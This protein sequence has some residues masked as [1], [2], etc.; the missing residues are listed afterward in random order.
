MGSNC[1]A[2]ASIGCLFCCQGCN[3][4]KLRNAFTFLPPPASYTVEEQ[5]HRGP[6]EE[7]TVG[8]GK[9][10]YLAEGLQA[11]SCYQQA[12]DNADVRFISTDGG[13]RIPVVW[14]RQNASSTTSPPPSN[15]QAPMVLLHCHGNATDI[16]MMMGPYFELTKQL[17]LDVVGVEYSGYGMS[18]GSPSTKTVH[19]DIEA[20]YNY[21]VGTG[22]PA[23]RI[24]AYGQSVGS[25]PVLG[26]A[27][28]KPLG[29]VVLHS[30]MLSGIKV[31]DPEPDS[32]CRPSC[33]Y[34]C[35]DFFPNDQRMK[36]VNCPAFVLHG[37]M[38]D[39][40]PFYHGHRLSE[41]TPRQHRWPSYFPRGA[42]HNDIVELNAN[43]YFEE[44]NAFVRGVRERSISGGDIIPRKPMQVEMADVLQHEIG[45]GS[46]PFSEPAVGPEDG[47]YQ[48]LRRG[49]NGGRSVRE[50][51]AKEGSTEP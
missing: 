22:V 26:L 45:A 30:P 2:S 37:Q 50:L 25:G 31:I 23:E 49:H 24:V 14:V 35:F 3:A 18:T 48:T 27:A 43:T 17:G 28:R 33:V 9:L 32:C 20:A 16:G 5:P 6:G 40:I 47:R 19:S 41:A 15:K 12:A 13:G 36:V 11:Y 21:V 29:G 7:L 10:V 42:G 46:L 39:I 51:Q 1:M 38:D 44:L 4:E 8:G 34:H